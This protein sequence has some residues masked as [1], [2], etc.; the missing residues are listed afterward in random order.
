MELY[1]TLGDEK[2]YRDTVD[3]LTVE[4]VW[5][6]GELIEKYREIPRTSSAYMFHS[7]PISPC[8]MLME[9]II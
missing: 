5:K 3:G 7:E 8:S 1:A 4:E 2:Y 9:K 6:N